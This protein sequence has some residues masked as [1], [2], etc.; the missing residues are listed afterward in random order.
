MLTDKQKEKLHSEIEMSIDRF[1][2]RYVNHK[3]EVNIEE[4]S[5]FVNTI[6]FQSFLRGSGVNL[7]IDGIWGPISKREGDNINI[8]S[9]VFVDGSKSNPDGSPAEQNN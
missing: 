7:T 6:A 1:I 4:L 9:Y 3:G 8:T 2:S 5:S